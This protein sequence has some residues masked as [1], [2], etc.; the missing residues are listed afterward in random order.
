MKVS[1]FTAALLGLTSYQQVAAVQLQ[2]HD[3]DFADYELAEIGGS[4]DAEP[5]AA[6]EVQALTDAECEQTVNGVV[7]RLDTPE[8]NQVA[9]APSPTPSELA[10]KAVA[11]LGSKASQ[12]ENALALLI[13]RNKSLAAG[14]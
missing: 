7:L 5:H 2:G 13:A 10:L 14:H 4:G 3:I 8:C 11:E 1:F 6:S 9:P 12:L